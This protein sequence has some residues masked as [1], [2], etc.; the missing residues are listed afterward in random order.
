MS[1]LKPFVI[2]AAIVVV[3]VLAAVTLSAFAPVN[4]ESGSW[5]HAVSSSGLARD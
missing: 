3:A 2:T 5:S 4:H 1:S